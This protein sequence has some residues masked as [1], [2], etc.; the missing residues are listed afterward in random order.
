MFAFTTV[1]ACAERPRQIQVHRSAQFVDRS[2]NVSPGSIVA[3]ADTQDR[4]LSGEIIVQDEHVS[5]TGFVLASSAVAAAVSLAWSSLRPWKV[6]QRKVNG[7]V[8]SYSIGE[9]L[10]D[11]SLAQAQ[12]IKRLIAL[13][14]ENVDSLQG[15][16]I[17][18]S[19]VQGLFPS[20]RQSTS[21]ASPVRAVVSVRQVFSALNIS[22][23][24]S[25]RSEQLE[26]SR[27]KQLGATG[28]NWVQLS[29]VARPTAAT[30]SH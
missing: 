19:E 20:V 25:N 23:F 18:D 8:D 3:I 28:C 16:V 13:G 21:E 29:V 2:R 27:W 17:H 4:F 9:G 14:G 22:S 11:H 30:T 10:P 1:L 12:A 26:V 24:I 7:N 5:S 6:P 15:D